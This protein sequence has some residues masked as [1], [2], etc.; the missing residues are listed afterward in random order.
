MWDNDDNLNAVPEASLVK[1]RR[2]GLL[3]QKT[4]RDAGLMVR[5]ADLVTTPSATL[6]E[7]YRSWGADRVTVVGNF[8][9]ASWSAVPPR[10][11]DG[12]VIGWVAGEEHRHDLERLRIAETLAAL[13]GRHADVRIRSVGLDMGFS[14]DDRCSYVKHVPYRELGAELAGFDVGIAPL[15]DI[16]F[17]RARSD[18]KLKEYAAAGVP[19][20]A[21]PIGPYAGLGEK[22]GGRLVA[23]GDWLAALD[24]IVSKGRSG[25]SWRGERSTGAR[26]RARRATPTA[27]RR[28]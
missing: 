4:F 5:A 27:G 20:L 15:D 7:L 24:R 8:L 18:V 21:S 26:D 11:H 9:P 14:G 3:D 13:L 23:D 6:A 25:A 22:Q 12:V 2:G 10:P 16:P 19:W 28:R 1:N 17:N